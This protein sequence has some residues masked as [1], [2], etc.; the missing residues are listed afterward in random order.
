V[1]RLPN[2]KIEIVVDAQAELAAWLAG[3]EA[4]LR[5]LDA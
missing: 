1:R 2:G 3:L 4:R 5:A